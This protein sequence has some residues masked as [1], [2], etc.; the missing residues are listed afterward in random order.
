MTLAKKFLEEVR[1]RL[2][3]SFEDRLLIVTKVLEVKIRTLKYSVL[4]HLPLEIA[5]IEL[6]SRK[7]PKALMVRKLRKLKS[8]KIR[9]PRKVRT[10]RPHPTI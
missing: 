6:G 3:L 7:T 2:L 1:R 9:C 10:S 4:S 5:A 8:R